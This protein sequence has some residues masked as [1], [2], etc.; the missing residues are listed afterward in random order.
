VY[1]ALNKNRLAV[2]NFEKFLER[3]PKD[4]KDRARAK[5]AIRQLKK[6]GF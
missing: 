3:A 5:E 4:D 6:R 2:E 1:A